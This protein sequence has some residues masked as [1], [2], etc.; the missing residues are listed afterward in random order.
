M[1]YLVT[2]AFDLHDAETDDYQRMYRELAGLGLSSSLVG[3][4]GN[5][6]TLPATTVCGLFTGPDS[7]G[8]RAHVV[9]GCEDAFSRQGL[10][11]K[12]LVVVGNDWAWDVRSVAPSLLRS[13]GSVG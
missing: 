8:V 6:A 2:V 3:V 7:S 12:L 10:S 13:Y 4:Q 1:E 11:G 9:R 5:R